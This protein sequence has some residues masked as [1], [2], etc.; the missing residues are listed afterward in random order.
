MQRIVFLLTYPIIWVFSKLPFG[1]LHIFS[2]LIYY[3]LYYVIGYRKEV[4]LN[5]LKL[6]FPD[7]S[8]KE[9]L[10]IRKKFFKHFVD[11]LIEMTKSFTI[12]EEE[13][14]RRYKYTNPE[15][16]REMEALGKSVILMGSHYANWEWI[17][18]IQG[19]TSIN[20]VGAY[21]KLSNPYYDKLIRKNR[22]RFGS[23]FV[24]TSATIKNM[25]SNKQNNIISMY[26]LLSDQTPLLS[27]THYWA[28]FLGIT[29]PIH[30]GAEML[31]KKHDFTVVYMSV[32]RVKR[33]HYEISFEILTDSPKQYKNYEI[34]DIFLEKA[35][36]Q[37]REKPEYYFWTHK[38]FK[39]KDSVPSESTK[40][41]LVKND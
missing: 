28:P 30:T 29:V 19:M 41:I 34:T 39:H 27:K 16:F 24:P 2:N 8:E 18:N 21:S 22:S 36:K 9:L 6:S 38:R 35:E 10:A 37:I 25:I 15:V 31:A 33:S 23:D 32:D 3:V 5:N 1:I 7:K 13:I 11:I 40:K 20:C 12:S 26:G 4:V 14:N 17:I